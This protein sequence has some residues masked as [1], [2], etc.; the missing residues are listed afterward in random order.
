MF[1]LESLDIY[2]WKDKDFSQ[3]LKDHG[4]ICIS[5]TTDDE[6][7]VYILDYFPN[8]MENLEKYI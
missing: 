3:T 8:G 7:W 1:I 5:R 2:I 4:Q 6:K